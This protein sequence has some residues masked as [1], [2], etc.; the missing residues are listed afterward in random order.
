LKTGDFFRI[1]NENGSFVTLTYNDG[2]SRQQEQLSPMQP[3]RLDSSDITIGRLQDNK[4]ML[5]H[6]QVS[7]HH[8]LLKRE[9]GT[10][11]IVDLN[12]TNHVY[13]KSQ[14]ATSALLKM[15]DETGIASESQPLLPR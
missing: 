7:A 5:P 14:A 13:V 3:I 8:A 12:S 9:G 15:G 10:Y 2:S 4:V 1:V 11:R 6:P